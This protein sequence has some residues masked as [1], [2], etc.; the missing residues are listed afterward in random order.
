MRPLFEVWETWNC[1]PFEMKP[2]RL[3]AASAICAHCGNSIKLF[4][5]KDFVG[6]KVCLLLTTLLTNSLPLNLM[7][8][9]FP[10]SILI[11]VAASFVVSKY[12]LD[13]CCEL[14]PTSIVFKLA[15]GNRTIN[16]FTLMWFVKTENLKWQKLFTTYV[17]YRVIKAVAN[18]QWQLRLNCC[19]QVTMEWSLEETQLIDIHSK[20][21]F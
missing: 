21:C 10:D 6:F 2:S 11:S 15:N 9:T 13:K 7:T 3:V 4:V 8:L 1:F 12:S 18:R 17:S 20:S 19:S 5:W 16:S 14:L